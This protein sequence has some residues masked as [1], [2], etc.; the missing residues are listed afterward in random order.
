M[1]DA[2]DDEA[3]SEYARGAGNVSSR[4]FGTSVKRLLGLT[5]SSSMESGLL[6]LWATDCKSST[7]REYACDKAINFSDIASSSSDG[8]IDVRVLKACTGYL[9]RGTRWDITGRQIAI[10]QACKQV[11]G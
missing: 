7:T 4:M 6:E 9:W 1:G 10:R 3:S 5:S 11:F 8:R 2:G